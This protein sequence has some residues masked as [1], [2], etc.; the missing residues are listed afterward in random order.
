LVDF[1]THK[2]QRLTQGGNNTGPCFSP[3]GEWISFA[4]DRDG[5]HEVFI[6]QMDGS[7]VTQLTYDPDDDWQPRWGLAY[8]AG[9]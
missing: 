8:K 5:D 7:R 6:M 2:T 9:E 1:L 3:D 4:S